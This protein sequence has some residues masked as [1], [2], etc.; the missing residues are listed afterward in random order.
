MSIEKIRTEADIDNICYW[1]IYG[2]NVNDRELKKVLA[3]GST[4]CCPTGVSHLDDLV[5]AYANAHERIYET[6]PR[7]N[8]PKG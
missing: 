3:L 1:L 7:Y 5:Q 2:G 4:G 6:T 8:Y